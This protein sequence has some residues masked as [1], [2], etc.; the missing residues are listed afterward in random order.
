LES[1]R[2]ETELAISEPSKNSD[3][4]QAEAVDRTASLG[5]MTSWITH[6]NVVSISLNLS[7]ILQTTADG[8]RREEES[9]RRSTGRT[10]ADCIR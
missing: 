4:C 8:T 7:K 1:E 10:P 5:G 9:G 6:G 3:A 2:S